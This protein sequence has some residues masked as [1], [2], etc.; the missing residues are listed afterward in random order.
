MSFLDYNITSFE[1]IGWENY[2][3]LYNDKTFHKSLMNTIVL[4]L[5]AVPIVIAF[6]IFVAMSIYKKS[7]FIRSFCRGIF[8]LPAVTSVVS[9]TVVWG[10]I[11]HPNFGILNYIT[12]FFGIEPISWLGDPRTALMA[13]TLILITTS[14]GQP[15]ILYVASLGNIPTTYIEAA[16]IDRATPWQVFRKI[17]WPLLMPTSLYVIVITT[18]NSFQCFALIQLLTSGGPIYSTS[19]VMYQVYQ[20]AFLLGNFGLASAMGVILA[21]VIGVI[22]IIQFKYLGNDVEY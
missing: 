17:I 8:Y 14:V 2:V 9:V 15:I 20:E 6:S 16:E 13:I 10:W 21:V 22:S 12:G 19:T 5:V 4:V 7:E 11:Y 18:I 1:F 3:T